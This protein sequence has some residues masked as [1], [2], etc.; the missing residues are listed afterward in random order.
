MRIAVGAVYHTLTR[1]SLKHAIPWR[2]VELGFDHQVG[3][4]IGERCDD[5][6]A[7]A[8]D[9]ARVGGAPED[10]AVMQIEHIAPGDMVRDH[11]LVYMDGALG[12]AGGA[13]RK[14]EQGAVA[15]PPSAESRRLGS[16]P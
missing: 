1:S 14:V 4:A 2:R 15:R 3:Y 12:P 10:V 5:A 7:R 6:V 8:G 11:R 13:A 9:P 16:P